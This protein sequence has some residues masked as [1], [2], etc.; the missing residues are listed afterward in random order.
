MKNIK[1]V[2]FLI[3]SLFVCQTAISQTTDKN[4]R[5][6][7][8]KAGTTTEAPQ[9]HANEVFN[10]SDQDIPNTTEQVEPEAD[11]VLPLDLEIMQEELNAS[12][13]PQAVV[14]K[15][16]AMSEELAQLRMFNEQLRLENRAIKKSLGSCCSEIGGN[17]TAA[18][19]YLMQ[20]APNPAEEASV[21]NY[22]VPN[23]MRSAQIKIADVT[24]NVIQ[25]I[26]VT[27]G[28]FGKI[29]I[30]RATFANGTYI[31]SL[32]VN[33]ELIDTKVMIFTN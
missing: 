15:L 11:W 7:G 16:N 28:G 27:E 33:N 12:A 31:Y 17:L 23:D 32:E 5:L 14:E 25:T 10:G 20:N 21:I 29:N 19:A 30:D 1:I 26:D 9:I 8:S 6:D 3:L 13:S 4:G 22:F 18:D 24:G 2:S